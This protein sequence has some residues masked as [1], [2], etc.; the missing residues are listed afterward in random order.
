MA[1]EEQVIKYHALDAW[2][3]TPQ[4]LR[5]A[6]AFTS[7]LATVSEFLQGKQLVQLGSCG[8]NAW[9]SSLHFRH[10][11]LLTPCETA[12]KATI[13]TSL[14]S[15]PLE[16]NSV[17]CVIAPLTLEAFGLE[18]SPLDEIDRILKP[19]GYVIF[20]GINPLSF[21]G[22][23]LRFHFI[24]CFGQTRSVV[25]SSLLLKHGMLSRGYTQC[26]LKSFYYI[27]PV[28]HKNAIKRL[29]FFNEMGKMIWP[30]PAGFYCFIVQKYQSDTLSLLFPQGDEELLCFSRH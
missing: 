10:Q 20:F 28:T 4:G 12:L 21:W 1:L 23:G 27:P 26:L 16:R 14:T 2:F 24:R 3:Q 22:A 9:L 5:V 18:K 8:D 29:E 7:E 6:Q 17:D 19:M 25:T 13:F 15:L 30:F 11:W